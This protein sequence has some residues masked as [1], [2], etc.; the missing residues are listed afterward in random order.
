VRET[1]TERDRERQGGRGR[2]REERE[3]ERERE[4][5]FKHMVFLMFF[6]AVLELTCF[7]N[8]PGLKLT[9]IP[10][11]LSLPLKCED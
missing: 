7:I 10:L 1:E 9:E 2:E 11:P 3:R 5:V 8:Q 4:S 6:L